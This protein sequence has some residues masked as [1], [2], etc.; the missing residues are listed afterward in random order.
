MVAN[1]I[2]VL[3]G[4]GLPDRRPLQSGDVS[5]LMFPMTRK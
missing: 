1:A 5:H 2:C 4:I 3:A